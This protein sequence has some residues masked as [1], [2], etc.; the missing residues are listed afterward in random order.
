MH[1]RGAR[2]GRAGL[3]AVR[4]TLRGC[5]VAVVRFVTWDQ[6][7]IVAPRNPRGLHEVSDLARR[8]V[9]I[10]NRERGSGARA[11]LDA[12]LARSGLSSSS[13]H[14]Y[15]REAFTHLAVAQAVSLGLVDAGVGIRA[16]AHAYGLGF[17]PLQREHYDLVIPR[18]LLVHPPVEAFL[19]VVQRHAV[20]R[21]LEAAGG[22]DTSGLGAEQPVLS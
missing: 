3:A 13:I 10:V 12:E 16:A 2:T 9:S 11:L 15:D 14:G 21:D 19:E 17:V 4:R 22:Y 7:L 20:R 1:L 5:D 18:A 6:G 8:G